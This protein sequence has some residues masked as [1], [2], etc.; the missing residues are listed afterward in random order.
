MERAQLAAQNTGVTCI[1][2]ESRKT[3]V[4]GG[5]ARVDYRLDRMAAY[6][7]AMN[8]DP[9]KP[10]VASAQAYF[11][12]QTRR[13]ETAQP[14]PAPAVDPE[15]LSVAVSAAVSQVLEPMSRVASALEDGAEV[16]A[17]VREAGSAPSKRG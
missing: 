14:A 12:V 6:L 3:P 5:P 2:A 4:N 10:E 7:V 16:A 9:R 17:G 1:F 8:G 13:A 15:A 11:A